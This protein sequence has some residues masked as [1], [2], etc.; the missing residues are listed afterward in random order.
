MRRAFVVKLTSEC[1]PE[2]K[3]CGRVEHLYS[4][5]TLRFE[6]LD[7]FLKFLSLSLENEKRIETQEREAA[8]EF[9]F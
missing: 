2:N 3:L 7:Q 6:S 5:Q 9:Q 8:N 4:G 1:D